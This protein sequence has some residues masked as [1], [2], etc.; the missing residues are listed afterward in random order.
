MTFAVWVR[1]SPVDGVPQPMTKL[2]LT[3]TKAT[4]PAQE[5]ELHEKIVKAGWV[6]EDSVYIG[7]A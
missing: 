6:V 2:L 5:R 3:S 7:A 1:N 4:W